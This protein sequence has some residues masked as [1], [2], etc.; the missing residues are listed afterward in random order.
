MQ[1]AARTEGRDI[2]GHV[3]PVVQPPHISGEH[4]LRQSRPTEEGPVNDAQQTVWRETI[5]THAWVRSPAP[6][7]LRRDPITLAIARRRAR[8]RL[9]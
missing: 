4:R 3:P 1:A 2:H 5:G 6:V 7:D 8:H 9:R